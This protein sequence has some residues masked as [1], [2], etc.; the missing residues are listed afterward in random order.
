[1]PL[2]VSKQPV[3]LPGAKGLQSEWQRPPLQV[4]PF[5]HGELVSHLLHTVLPELGTQTWSLPF[6]RAVQAVLGPQLVFEQ[7]LQ[8]P[9]LAAP[10]QQGR[11]NARLA[12]EASKTHARQA[13]QTPSTSQRSPSLPLGR[14]VPL[15]QVNPTAHPSLAPAEVHWAEHEVFG[16]QYPLASQS[17]PVPHWALF[18]HESEHQSELRSVT[19]TPVLQSLPVVQNEHRSLVPSCV[20][21]A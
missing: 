9:S 1:M 6:A 4:S 15:K 5:W 17:Y 8:N 14:Q 3:Q 7:L 18:E 20:R 2:P 11:Q 21:H 10:P 19:Q 13:L 12:P 16:T